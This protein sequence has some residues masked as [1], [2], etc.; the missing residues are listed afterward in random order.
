MVTRQQLVIDESVYE[1]K[2]VSPCHVFIPR[3]P[4]PNGLLSYGICGYTAALKLPM[5]VDL[6]PWL[7]GN[8][9]SAQKSARAL[10]NRLLDHYGDSLNFHIVTDS[11]FGSFEEADYYLS[12]NVKI[13]SSMAH[14][15]KEWLWSMLVSGCGINSGRIALV[16]LDTPGAYA[17]A[18]AYHVISESNKVIDIRTITTA[19]AWKRPEVIEPCVSRIGGRQLHARGY[20]EYETFWED[21]DI[22]WQKA[23][24]FIDADGTV[25]QQWLE[26]ATEEDLQAALARFTSAQLIAICEAQSLKVVIF[27]RVSHFTIA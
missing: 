20:Y 24:T 19:F 23:D 6:E 21:G 26:K 27:H 12:R 8:K 7:P 13:T 17:L 5:L 11:A 15:S 18:S 1:Y 25:T 14:K 22:T 9:L 10:V 16:P 2:G 3:K 4:H